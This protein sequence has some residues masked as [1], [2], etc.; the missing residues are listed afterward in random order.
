MV[1]LQKEYIHGCQEL[2]KARDKKVVVTIRYSVRDTCGDGINL[3]N[4]GNTL[5]YSKILWFTKT[6]REIE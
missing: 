6:L 5:Q 4:Y 1:K 2:R 3:L